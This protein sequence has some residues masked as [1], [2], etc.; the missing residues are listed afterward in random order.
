MPGP[1]AHMHAVRPGPAG[2]QVLGSRHGRV[3]W[4]GS[5]LLPSP[6]LALPPCERCG[7]PPW[8]ARLAAHRAG[9]GPR[10]CDICSPGQLASASPAAIGP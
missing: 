9:P 5:R 10:R 7:D 6:F 4:G 2:T 3:R 1:A 8:G